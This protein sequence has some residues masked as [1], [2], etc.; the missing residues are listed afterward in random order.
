MTARTSVS[1]FLAAAA[2]LST[3][4][5]AR[6]DAIDGNWCKPDGKHMSIRG[7]NIVTPTGRHTQGDYDRHA[8]SYNAPPK[9]PDA[10]QTINMILVDEDTVYLRV[11]AAPGFGPGEAEVWNRCTLP[12]S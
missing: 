10:G 7:P 11:G 1:L 9:D 12:T 6:A 5:V 8:F 2:L 3:T 4:V